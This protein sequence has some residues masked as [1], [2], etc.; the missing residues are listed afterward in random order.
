MIRC[1]PE[2]FRRFWLLCVVAIIMMAGARSMVAQ[3]LQ[4]PYTTSYIIQLRPDVEQ[5]FLYETMQAALSGNAAN[6]ASFRM[7]FPERGGERAALRAQG[8]DRYMVLEN[9]PS[10]PTEAL[11]RIASSPYVQK[12]F[13]NHS[14]KIASAP[15][16]SLYSDQWALRKIEAEGA[17]AVTTGDSS[18]LVGIIDTGLEWEHPDLVRAVWV[19][20]AED[21]NGNGRF[22]PWPAGETVEGVTG[23]LDGID[24]DGNGWV[25]DVI[26]YDFVDQ[27]VPNV[28][29]WDAWDPIPFDEFGHGTNVAGVIAATQNNE[30]GISGVAPGVRLVTMRAFDV[31]GNGQDDDISTA[32]VYAA[33]RGVDV[34]NLSFGDF[35]HSPL[36]RDAIRYARSKGVVVVA[37]SGNEGVPDPHYPSDFPEVISV[38]ATDSLD[39]L[40]TFSTYGS[41]ISLSAPGVDIF[42]TDAEGG[43]IETG[44]TSFA[45]PHV[46]GVAALLKSIHPSWTSEEIQAALELSADDAGRK[47][48]DTDHGAGRLNARRAIELPGPAMVQITSPTIDEGFGND[49]VVEIFGSAMSPFLESWQL[50]IGYGDLPREWFPLNEPQDAGK[51]RDKLGEFNTLEYSDTIITLRLRLAL[52][53]GHATEHRIRLYIDRTKPSLT[54]FE[55]DNVWRFDRRALGITLETDDLTRVTAW[56]RKAS[57]NGNEEVYRPLSLESGRIGLTRTH[58]LMLTSLEMERGVPY[59]LYLEVANTSGDTLSVGS[60][61]LPLLVQLEQEAFPVDRLQLKEYAIPFGFVLNEATDFFG[62]GE[63][64]ILL[65]RFRGGGFNALTLYTLSGEQFELSD[66]TDNWAPRDVGDSDGDG[67]LEVLGQASSRGIVYEQSS[68]NASPFATVLFSDTESANLFVSRFHDFDGDG[69]DELLAHTSDPDTDEDYY[70]IGRWNGETYEEIGRMTNPTLPDPNET[71][72]IFGASNTVIGDFNGNGQTDILIADNDADFLV[73]EYRP[74]GSLSLIWT[75]ENEGLE[76]DRMIAGGDLNND[77]Q[78]EIIVGYRSDLLSNEFGEYEPPFWTVK[79]FKLNQS[80]TAELLFRERFAFIRPGDPFRTGMETGDLDGVP[81]DELAISIFP[82]MYV[83]SWDATL[84]RLRPFW[85]HNNAVINNPVIQDYDGDGRAELAFGNGDSIYFYQIDPEAARPSAPAGFDG[86]ALSDSTVYLEWEPVPGATGYALYRRLLTPDDGGTTFIRIATLTGTEYVDTG[87]DLPA[88][89]LTA[90]AVYGYFVTTFD[91]T[92]PVQESDLGELVRVYVHSAPR[93]EQA[94]A[95]DGRQIRITMSEL[96]HEDLYRPGAFDVRTSAQEP[97]VISTVT[98]AGDYSVLVTLSQPRYDQI[99]TVTPT[100]LFRDVYRSPA[101]TTSTVTVQMPEAEEPGE[102]FIATRGFIAAAHT[103]GIDFN[104]PIDPGT[105][106]NATLYALSPDGPILDVLIDPNNTQ[107]VLLVMEEEYLLGAFG[108]DYVIRIDGTMR[109]EGGQLLNDGTGSVIGFTVNAPHLE[110][111]YVYPHPFSITQ[112][113]FVTFARLTRAAT[114]SIYTQS[115]QLVRQV[116]AEDGNGGAQWD[117]TTTGGGKVPT[118][119]YLYKIEGETAEGVGYTSPLRKI[120]VVP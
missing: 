31:T 101:D 61:A 21:I 106:T 39:R 111:V 53:N 68:E 77:G 14:Y 87:A 102:R 72:N 26:G 54:S 55:L 6:G 109:S 13:P 11:S 92:L 99:L 114:V 79:I 100:L 67:L 42:T 23:D 43:Y 93:I 38:S 5:K 73:Y 71:R 1:F 97:V 80:N 103:I 18:V 52:T 41:Q 115:G 35:Y 58:Y 94:I 7:L 29:D 120:A 90:N 62:D 116:E 108:K 59:D 49:Q 36:M 17:W 48:W 85:W 78:D 64:S 96:V 83:F 19:N 28:G 95:V 104:F 47:G 91:E 113:E 24:Q 66:S 46:S 20:P 98:N 34:L 88:G 25:D 82:N 30:I 112:D 69:R 70:F 107:R 117:G 50:F 3:D 40:S 60:A 63:Q 105:G 4:E 2:C 86:W 65:N 32:I 22:E 81:G 15:N 118:G 9:V 119:I 16:D 44:G 12:I 45:A 10:G 74:D 57:Q 89:R 56:L 84:N 27:D 75:D 8:L 110:E 76:S 51:V 37:S 33:D